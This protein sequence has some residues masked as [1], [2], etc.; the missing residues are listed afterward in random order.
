MLAI[1]GRQV[2]PGQKGNGCSKLQIC[3]NVEEHPLTWTLKSVVYKAKE[4]KPDVKAIKSTEKI[5]KA[6]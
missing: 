2:K 1:L 5:N 6:A 3:N 4:R